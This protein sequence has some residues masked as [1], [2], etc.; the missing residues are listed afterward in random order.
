MTQDS[1][2]EVKIQ[3]QQTEASGIERGLRQ[4]DA[5]ST[6]SF[7]IV[8][9]KVVR[10]LQTYLDGTIFNRTSLYIA[11]ADEVLI[12]G[13]TVW[14]TEVV[15][16]ESKEAAVSAGLE[17]SGKNNKVAYMKINR[18]ITNSEQDMMMNGQLLEEVPNFRYL[19]SLKKFRKFNK[20]WNKIKDC[21]E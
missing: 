8:L 10:N 19:G 12:L 6:A 17:I 20:W 1:N 4:G 13:W 5:L 21:C 3:G 2:G 14:A 7:N 9:D 18:N 15:V 16:T 11:Y